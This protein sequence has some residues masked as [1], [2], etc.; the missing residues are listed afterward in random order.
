MVL[1]SKH[2]TNRLGKSVFE[3]VKERQKQ[4]QIEYATRVFTEEK[5]YL[6][7]K[8]E[9]DRLLSDVTDLKKISIKDLR[10]ILKSLKRNG[11]KALPTKKAKMLELYEAWKDR[12]PPSF[13]YDYSIIDEIVNRDENDNKNDIDNIESV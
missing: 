13:E 11:D 9:A 5:T 2:G 1:L 12:G 10:T 3:V 8:E 6:K 7:L 4:K